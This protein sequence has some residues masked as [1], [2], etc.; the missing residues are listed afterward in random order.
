[1]AVDYTHFT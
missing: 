1:V